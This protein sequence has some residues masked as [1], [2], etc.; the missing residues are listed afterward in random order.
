MMN[1]IICLLIVV[2]CGQSLLFSQTK[3]DALRDAKIASTSTLKG[4]FD[5]LIK[6]T[7]PNVIEVMGGK[8]KALEAIESTF[9]SMAEEG[10]GFEK[11]DVLGVSEIVREQG[12][13]RCYIEGYNQMKM[14]GMR[15]KSKSYLLGFYNED[16]KIWCFIEASKIKDKT[17]MNRIFPNFQT[18]LKIPEDSMETETF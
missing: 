12:E 9:S 18:K 3:E 5:T 1:K 15:I 8:N 13:Y 2:I 11:A 4:D 16:N 17:L 7:H 10:L 14:P 6:H